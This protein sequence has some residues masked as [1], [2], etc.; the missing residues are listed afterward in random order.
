MRKLLLAVFTGCLL[1]TVANVRLRQPDRL[2]LGSMEVSI[3]TDSKA[4]DPNVVGVLAVQ[5]PSR[6]ELVPRFRQHV[7]ID[8]S[9][10]YKLYKD[11]LPYEELTI[12]ESNARLCL[13]TIA[14]LDVL[15]HLPGILDQWTNPISLALF[16]PNSEG[17]SLLMSFVHFL[18]KCRLLA[19]IALQVHA[20]LP[21][22]E[23]ANFTSKL[24]MARGFSCDEAHSL[25]ATLLAMS[26]NRKG[27]TPR[28]PQNVLRNLA[29][30]GCQSFRTT[31]FIAI[32][33]DFRP[34]AGL[35]TR[36][37]QFLADEP[38]CPKCLYVMAAFEAPEGLPV[39]ASKAD[40]VT[41][42]QN[43][44][45]DV[46]H[47]VAYFMN[48][49]ATQTERW[50]KL[51]AVSAEDRLKVAYE[52]RYEFGYEGFFMAPFG[53]PRY[54]EAFVGYGHT[55][56]TQLLLCY[57]EGYRFYLLNDGYLMH[58]GIRRS[59]KNNPQRE[60][61]KKTNARLFYKF[62]KKLFATYPKLRKEFAKIASTENE[63]Q[64]P[65]KKFTSSLSMKMSRGKKTS[66]RPIDVYSEQRFS[67]EKVKERS[68]NS[69]SLWPTAPITK[70]PKQ[71][72]DHTFRRPFHRGPLFHGNSDLEH[73][74]RKSWSRSSVVHII[75][76]RQLEQVVLPFVLVTRPTVTASLA[77]LTKVNLS[78]HWLDPDR[79]EELHVNG[80]TLDQLFKLAEP[81]STIRGSK[82]PLC[83]RRHLLFMH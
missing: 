1:W 68:V 57:A 77:T 73:A 33:I 12:T 70:A 41:L 37:E 11:L 31:H 75:R 25:H 65:A 51:D 24:D 56:S 29:V 26:S 35:H 8:S 14:S 63:G 48:Q 60:R 2:D 44:T 53:V 49:R 15:N 28:F 20:V 5:K 78:I 17:L 62:L 59:R 39:P 6:I 80:C 32:D 40:I 79:L 55:R 4:A 21:A 66:D 74:R 16:A 36:L 30:D 42:M 67:Y 58:D 71:Q 13:A 47:R 38:V 72:V 18:R 46:Y 50:L 83:L 81:S 54:V 43:H 7:V 64:K 19:R 10:R 52:I 3:S 9:R 34:S 22:R 45:I 27:K 23:R 76:C 69:S 61:E 82:K